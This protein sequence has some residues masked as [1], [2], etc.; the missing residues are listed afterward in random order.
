MNMPL[1]PH[2]ATPLADLVSP[3]AGSP[4]WH[5]DFIFGAGTSSYQIEGAAHEDGRLES[6]WDRFCATPGKV[7]RGENGDVACDHYHRWEADLDLLANLG[8]DAYRFSIAW[9]R[10]MDE[11]GRPNSRGIDFYKRLLDGLAARG[12]RAFATLYHWDLPQH[13]EDRGGWL[14]RETAY[15]F[16]DYADLM[17]RELAGGV[18]AWATHNEPWCAAYLGYADA[19]HAPGHRVTRWGTQ[20]MHHL[21]L[22]HGLAL[23]ALRA[24]DPNAAV[25][26]V[27]NLAPGYAATDSAA[28]R[29]AASLFETFQNRWVL[30]PLLRGEY[31]ADLWRLWKGAEPLVLPGDMEKIAQ[32]IDYLGINYYSRALL[33]SPEADKFDWV[34]DPGVE[35]TTMDW[36]VYPQGLQDL[37]EALKRDYANLPPIYITENGMSSDDR[38]DAA[39]VDDLQRQAYLKRHF[40]A[41]SRAMVN[42]VD[43]AGYFIWSL[44]DNFEWAFGYERRFG[45]VH[46][47]FETQARTLKQSALAYADFL[48][49]RAA[50]AG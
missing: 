3:P 25:G 47:D 32:P 2:V 35:R 46:V 45:L 1:D 43:V 48:R 50:A 10:V 8:V 12:M 13:L 17:S 31:P 36:E 28:D 40:E 7:L 22:G 19:H 11:A 34:R 41:C 23:P 18:T 5:Q 42:G 14:N 27:A 9:P 20:A 24:N 26:I 4:M 37:L 29:D 49:R 38:I 16:A 30:D 33:R 39:Q 21:L 15:R 44:M 6:I